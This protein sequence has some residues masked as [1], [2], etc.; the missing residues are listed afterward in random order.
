MAVSPIDHQITILTGPEV[1]IAGEKSVAQRRQSLLIQDFFSR[2]G[3]TPAA[4]KKP[5]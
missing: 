5:L 2:C 4:R 1:G 3:L